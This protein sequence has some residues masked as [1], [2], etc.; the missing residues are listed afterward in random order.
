MSPSRFTS[1]SSNSH[2]QSQLSSSSENKMMSSRTASSSSSTSSSCPQQESNFLRASMFPFL[3]LEICFTLSELTSIDNLNTELKMALH[4]LSPSLR[5]ALAFLV[6]QAKDSQKVDIVAKGSHYQLWKHFESMAKA[7]ITQDPHLFTS[8][9]IELLK[10]FIALPI[11]AKALYCRLMQRKHAGS[12]VSAVS[13]L[14]DDIV[15]RATLEA[16]TSIS[17]DEL[18]P[19]HCTFLESTVSSSSSSQALYNTLVIQF[20]LS[21][22]PL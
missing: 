12:W 1:E 5:V 10:R 20:A 13:L 14:R 16:L 22:F 2:S 6:Q 18:N 19:C 11:D 4:K 17:N 9:Q 15:T 3:S 8:H 7:S 21:I